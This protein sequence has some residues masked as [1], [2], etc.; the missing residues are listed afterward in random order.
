VIVSHDPYLSRVT[1]VEVI[2][3]FETK[4]QKR[5]YDGKIKDDWWVSDF[6]VAELK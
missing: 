4:K 6:T 5:L 2:K 3:E 1:N